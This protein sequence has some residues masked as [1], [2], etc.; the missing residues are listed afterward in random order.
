MWSPILR[1]TPYLILTYSRLF[2][3]M[4]GILVGGTLPTPAPP[5]MDWSDMV[6]IKQISMFQIEDLPLFSG[7]APRRSVE[8]SEAACEHQQHPLAAECEFCYATRLV[9]LCL[10]SDPAVCWRDAEQSSY[11]PPSRTKPEGAGADRADRM[12]SRPYA[13]S[14]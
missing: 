3:I 6:V 4:V 1:T 8:P 10:F 14:S 5:H 13:V 11:R 7:T 9:G 12:A 2:C